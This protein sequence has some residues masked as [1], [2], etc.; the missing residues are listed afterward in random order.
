MT[1]ARSRRPV[2]TQSVQDWAYR[3]RATE[4]SGSTAALS[5]S[6]RRTRASESRTSRTIAVT[7]AAR[8]A[9]HAGPAHPRRSEGRR[10]RAAG[11]TPV[12]AMN[13]ARVI[14]SEASESAGWRM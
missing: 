13:P 14:G 12:S 3:S 4:V 2:R 5:V 8:Q 7:C 10:S 1:N 11:S 9:S 6:P